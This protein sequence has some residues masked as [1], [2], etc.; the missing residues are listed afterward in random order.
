MPGVFEISRQV[1]IRFAI[2]DILLIAI[3][4]LEGE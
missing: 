4:S 2:D 3:Y 1:P